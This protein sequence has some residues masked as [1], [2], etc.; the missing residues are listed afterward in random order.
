MAGVPGGWSPIPPNPP[1]TATPEIQEL[2]NKLKPQIEEK[3]NMDLGAC[4][5]LYYYSQVVAGVNYLILVS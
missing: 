3:L 1:N 2:V 5:A 4:Q